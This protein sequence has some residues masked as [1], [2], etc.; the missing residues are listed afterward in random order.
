M[1]DRSAAVPNVE[2][3]SGH[4]ADA[5]GARASGERGQELTT[6]LVARV[7]ALQR[8]AGNAATVRALV[9]SRV[10]SRASEADPPVAEAPAD[11][12]RTIAELQT[13]ARTDPAAAWELRSRFRAMPAQ[14]L[15]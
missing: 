2:G 9:N 3:K 6:P 10:L 5:S 14:E 12:E 7:M 15:R 4:A 11:A 8:S 1:S 13:A